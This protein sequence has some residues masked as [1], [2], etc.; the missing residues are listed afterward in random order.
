MMITPATVS[1]RKTFPFPHFRAQKRGKGL[2]KCIFHQKKKMYKNQTRDLPKMKEK[3][4]T[5]TVLY[6]PENRW[7]F[8]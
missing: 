1:R 6:I 5:A 7:A 3:Q 8:N 2:F 4:R